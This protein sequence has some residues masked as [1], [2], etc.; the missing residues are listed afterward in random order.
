L[1]DGPL[2]PHR[3]PFDANQAIPTLLFDKYKDAFSTAF[4]DLHMI[5]NSFM[6]L[7]CYP[8]SG[9]FK[10]WSLIPS[11]GI[12]PILWLEKKMEPYLGQ[13]FGFRLFVVLE[14]REIKSEA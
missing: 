11:F 5:E 14:K 6:S 9:G 3:K 7:W 2:S 13:L 10:P 12:K 1:E 4:P 8:L